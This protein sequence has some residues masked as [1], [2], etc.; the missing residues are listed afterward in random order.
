MIK[1]RDCNIYTHKIF[2]LCTIAGMNGISVPKEIVSNAQMYTDW[3]AAGCYDLHFTVR[4]DSIDKSLR[5]A[6]QWMKELSR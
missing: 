3:E 6:Q 5:L 4:V 1:K 2:N